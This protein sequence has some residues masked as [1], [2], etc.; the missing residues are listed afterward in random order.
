VSTGAGRGSRGITSAR[1]GASGSHTPPAG[2]P[3]VP[4]RDIWHLREEQ[5][6]AAARRWPTQP[7]A[8]LAT[9]EAKRRE[10][11]AVLLDAPT[12]GRR[13]GDDQDRH[14]GRGPAAE[15]PRHERRNSDLD[16]ET[17]EQR[18]KVPQDR[19][20]LDDEQHVRR[21]VVGQEID[22]PTVAVPVEADLGS[23]QPAPRLEASLPVLL[24]ECVTGVYEQP[25][26][27][28]A[29]GYVD[30]DACAKSLDEVAHD[31]DLEASDPARLELDERRSR[32]A[33]AFAEVDL[34]PT[35]AVPQRAHWAPDLLISHRADDR[36]SPITGPLAP[37]YRAAPICRDATKRFAT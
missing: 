14:D 12:R 5:T 20:D 37:A 34:P 36:E 4:G 1:T 7:R 10:Q 21:G 31:V 16:V 22:P 15:L 13:R 2:A 17:S 26:I 24:N 25:R 33:G 30:P 23:N 9:A 19:L 28:C 11:C 18:L 29:A 32:P 35:S 8:Q 3:K 27:G 6:A